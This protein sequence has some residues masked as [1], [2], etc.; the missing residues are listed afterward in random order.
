MRKKWATISASEFRTSCFKILDEATRKRRSVVITKRGKPV[1]KLVPLLP[2][3]ASIF[4]FF[5]GKGS[6]KGDLVSPI[7]SPK[8]WGS[9]KLP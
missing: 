9:L 7:A 4:G 8:E 5:A 1:A 6:I 2:T 3:K